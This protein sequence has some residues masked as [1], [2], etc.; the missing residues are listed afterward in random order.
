MGASLIRSARHE[1]FSRCWVREVAPRPFSTIEDPREP[2]RVTHLLPEVL[3]LAV[4]GT[5][6]DCEDYDL[7]AEWGAA[8]LKPRRFG[9]VFGRF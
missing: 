3:L 7:I 8:H 6:C 1:H 2:W 4:C 9:A 5:I